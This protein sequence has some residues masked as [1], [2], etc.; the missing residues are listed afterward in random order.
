MM[1]RTLVL[2]KPDGVQRGLIGRITQRFEDAGLKIVGMKMVQTSKEH[3]QKHYFDVEQRRGKKVFDYNVN[4]LLEGPV[5]AFVLEGIHSVEQVRKMVGPT[6]PKAAPPGTI[7][8]DFTH[9]SYAYADAQNQVIRNLVHASA[10]TEDAKREIEL[11]FTPKE[12]QD[13]KTV[14]ERHVFGK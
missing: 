9:Q 2:I 6:E 4:F 1:E 11:W 3:A 10:N 8:G 13:Y 14:H 5:V 12:L 7:R